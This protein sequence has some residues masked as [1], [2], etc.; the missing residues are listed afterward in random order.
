MAFIKIV[1]L[2][3]CGLIIVIAIVLWYKLIEPP[4]RPGKLV[5]P[6]FFGVGGNR[7]W[8]EKNLFL[9]SLI[10]LTHTLPHSLW[11]PFFAWGI[12]F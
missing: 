6:F 12:F 1:I 3:S 8:A 7:R 9:L 5:G 10:S 11:S 4:K 2:K